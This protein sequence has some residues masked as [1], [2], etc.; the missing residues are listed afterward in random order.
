MVAPPPGVSSTSKF[1]TDRL[2]EP[3]GHGEAQA[4]AGV[5]VGIAESLEG[6]EDQVTILRPDSRSPIDDTD[7]DSA[8]DGTGLDPEADATGMDEGVVDEVGHGPF[9]EDRIG[10]D[11]GEVRRHIDG[12]RLATRTEA[13]DGGVDHVTHID[14]RVEHVH[15]AGLEPSHVQQVL[16]QAVEPVGLVVDRLQE[17]PGSRRDRRSAGRRGGSTMP[18]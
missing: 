11:P 12:D 13:L 2:D 14:A 10:P 1:A 18:P 7:V 6:S 17:D 15:R 9:Q 5:V 4:H 3:S 8:G 16:H